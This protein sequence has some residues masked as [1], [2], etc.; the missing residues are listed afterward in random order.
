MATRRQELA[1]EGELLV[2]DSCRCLVCGG[3]LRPLRRSLPCADVRCI[4]CRRPAQVR[5]RRWAAS[6]GLPKKLAG[7][8]WAPQAGLLLG[9]ALHDLLIV[10]VGDRARDGAIYALPASSQDARLFRPRN[11][12][13]AAAR[14]KGL[15]AFTY[16]LEPF[17]PLLSRIEPG[18]AGARRQ[19]VRALPD[20][21]ERRRSM[22]KLMRPASVEHWRQ[23]W[24][25]LAASNVVQFAR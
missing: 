21:S 3:A 20:P 7:A 18:H 16:E 8:A 12:L 14:Q 19:V 5:T 22:A 4:E 25:P 24:P 9:D 1:I 2:V 15:Q 13:G 17:W 23:S 6:D 11:V 10:L